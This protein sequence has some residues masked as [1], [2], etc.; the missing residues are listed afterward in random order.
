MNLRFLFII[1]F[2]FFCNKAFGFEKF[3]LNDID[4]YENIIV[5]DMFEPLKVTG[6]ALP[7]QLFG[8]TKEVEDVPLIKMVLITVLSNQFMTIKLKSIMGKL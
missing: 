4:P 6:D 2:T 8:K 3:N 1:V 7:W 5:E